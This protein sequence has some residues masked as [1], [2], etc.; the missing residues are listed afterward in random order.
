MRFELGNVYM[1]HGIAAARENDFGFLLEV[2]KAFQRYTK[3][4]FGELCEEDIKAN[5]EAIKDGLRVLGC[6]KTSKGDIYI[7]TEADRSCTT[8]LFCDEY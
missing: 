8:I 6:Y 1:T 3:E 2:E 7:I 5:E 4:D